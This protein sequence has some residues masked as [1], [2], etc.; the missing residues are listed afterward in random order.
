MNVKENTKIN[1]GVGEPGDS[2]VQHGL[3]QIIGTV[4]SEKSQTMKQANA[5]ELPLS[6]ETLKQHVLKLRKSLIESNKG[7]NGNG[8]VTNISRPEEYDKQVEK[9]TRKEEGHPKNEH[10][11]RM[12]LRDLKK[13]N[14]GIVDKSKI[15]LK[16]VCQIRIKITL[17]NYHLSYR[18]LF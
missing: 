2:V 3:S 13:S 4:L 14:T 8:N 12:S 7:T 5:D 6:L 15:I 1:S 10:E 17:L 16:L 9:D 18:I 11:S